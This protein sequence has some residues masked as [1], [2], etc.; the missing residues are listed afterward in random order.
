MLGIEKNANLRL[1]DIDSVSNKTALA[2]STIL[3]WESRNIFPKAIRLSATKRVW[4]E[5]DIDDW[6]LSKH[7]QVNGQSN[8]VEA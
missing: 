1:I 6:I 7:A 5:K 3:A 4:L 8:L 2:S